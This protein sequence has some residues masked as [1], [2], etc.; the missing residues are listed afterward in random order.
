KLPVRALV[1]LIQAQLPADEVFAPLTDR[2]VRAAI[3]ALL[4][5][6]A[7]ALIGLPLAAP[8][9][10]P[11]APLREAGR[12]LARGRYLLSS[13]AIRPDDRPIGEERRRVLLSGQ[14]SVDECRIITKDGAVRIL[15]AYARPVWD[16][17]DG[18]IVRI[19]GAGQDLTEQ[20][21]A[22]EAAIQAK[23]DADAA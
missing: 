18:R 6:A 7:S 3:A 20:R 15:Q 1:E 14:T 9:A 2:P 4:V 11:I 12:R 21:P 19:Y 23:S 5:L 8:L 13:L 10:A 22:E 17:A 16:S